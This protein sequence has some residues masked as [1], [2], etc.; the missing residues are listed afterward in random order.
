MRLS[1]SC[2]GD[3][4]PF[5]P[6]KLLNTKMREPD[7]A[8]FT[9]NEIATLYNFLRNI[10]FLPLRDEGSA[11]LDDRFV[12]DI[13]LTKT[14]A[15]RLLREQPE[16][17]SELIRHQITADDVAVLGHRRRQLEVFHELLTDERAF[18]V[19][20]AKLGKEK[21]PED[22]W[23][24]FFEENTWIF[25][26]G[27]NYYFN[28]P[29]D[30]EQLEQVIRGFDFSS[31]GKRVD[32]LLKTNG[33]V[34]ALSFVE[35][36]THRTR[37]IKQLRR[38]YRTESW[39]ISED[40]AGGLAQVQRTVQVSLENIRTRTD[41]TGPNGAPTGEELFLYQSRAVLVVGS[42]SEFEGEHGINEEQYS[43]FEM[44]RR[45]IVN[46]E[47]ITFDELYKRA[48]CIVNSGEGLNAANA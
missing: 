18:E 29:L 22:V 23:Q 26:Y 24:S 14:Q 16:L 8:T 48:R 5:R 43:S 47:I 46:P 20:R 10:Q 4:L 36:K 38:P 33:F 25:G 27:L 7:R 41:V 1:S 35:I 28:S 9:G 42:W 17:V 44:F 6:P 11:K 12:E 19:R 15:L 13:V 21:R 2:R 39:Q 30:D 40:L 45:N 31:S 37:L 32:A 3:S 34:S